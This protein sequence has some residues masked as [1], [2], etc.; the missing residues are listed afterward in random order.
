MAVSHN[1]CGNQIFIPDVGSCD[2]CEQFESRLLNVEEELDGKQD[3]LT[4]GDG[5]N[6]SGNT[7]SADLSVVQEKLVAGDGIRIADDVI[8][9]LFSGGDPHFWSDNGIVYI[10]EEE[11]DNYL[12]TGDGMAVKLDDESLSVYHDSTKLMEVKLNLAGTGTVFGTGTTASGNDA[13]ADGAGTVASGDNSHAGGHGTIANRAN[14]TSIGK[15]NEADIGGDNETELGEYAF[16]IGNGTSNNNRSNALTV[17]WDGTLECANVSDIE[18]VTNNITITSTMTDSGCA[19][20]KAVRYGK[21]LML[22]LI[23]EKNTQTTPGNNLFTGTI[24]Q[25]EYWPAL[26][27]TGGCGF[28]QSAAVISTLN[29]SGGITARVTAGNVAANGSVYNYFTYLIP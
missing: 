24:D 2:E 4:A 3:T 28:Y 20:Q 25:P 26:T 27:T 9:A 23:Y 5:I 12:N 17:E 18:D 14:Q 11:K 16:I 19:V 29:D 7:V 15:Y 13:F 1:G 10:T 22:T 6:I 21:V 8:S